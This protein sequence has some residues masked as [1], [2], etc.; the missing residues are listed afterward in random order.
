MTRLNLQLRPLFAEWTAVLV[1]QALVPVFGPSHR[2]CTLSRV[3]A[4][5]FAVNETGDV[6]LCDPRWT[7]AHGKLLPEVLAKIERGE[8]W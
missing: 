3:K 5:R 4:L 1:H 8:S 6:I 2:R 7:D